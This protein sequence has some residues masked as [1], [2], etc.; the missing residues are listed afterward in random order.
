MIAW[1]V[2][3]ERELIEQRSLFDLPMS[4]HDSQSCFAQRLNQRTSGVAT[5]T[6]STESANSGHCVWRPTHG[7][8]GF[9]WR[10]K[11]IA[12][13]IAAEADHAHAC[14]LEDK[15]PLQMNIAH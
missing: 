11:A 6:F 9:K 10:N 5:P 8:L 3:F 7:A 4:H 13:Y 12:P 14:C 15:A 1:N 2:L